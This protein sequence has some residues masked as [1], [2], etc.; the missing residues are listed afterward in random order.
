MRLQIFLILCAVLNAHAIF[1]V[2]S[3]SLL[4]PEATVAYGEQVHY[5]FVGPGQ[6]FTIRI[7]PIVRSSDGE[8]LG[9]WD[10]AD[11][12]SL[13]DG[14]S[15]KPS[16]L[17][18]NPLIVEI[19]ARADASEGEYSI[20]IS[21]VD[22][23]GQENIGGELSFSV[24]VDVRH[25]VLSMTVEP[26]KIE[27]GAGQP[28]RFKVILNNLGSA[29]DVYTINASGVKGWEF[30]RKIYLPPGS[31]KSFVY[32]VVGNDEAYYS[33]DF[34][35]VSD[36]SSLIHDEAQ[37]DLSVHTSL[38]SDYKATSH[39]VLLFP[40]ISTPIYSLAGLIGLLFP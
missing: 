29:K 21:V 39:G 28:A 36:S 32:E 19:T 22:E 7:E 30:Q 3:I 9:Q 24:L 23:Q 34:S 38:I 6:T 33:V 16:K 18:A 40:L 10:M 35:A 1:S 17:Y 20:P 27:T 14:W 37:V 12:T 31:Q 15:A 4:E 26:S 8:F 13:P 2:N 5:G 11:A 25:D